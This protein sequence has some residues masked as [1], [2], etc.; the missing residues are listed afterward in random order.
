MDRADHREPNMGVQTFDG[1]KLT[2][3]E[4]NTGKNYLYADKMYRLYLLSEQFLL[5]AESTALAGREMTMASLH[6]QLDRLLELN[7]YPV[8]EG[9]KDYLFDHGDHISPRRSALFMARSALRDI[10]DG[11]RPC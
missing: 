10:R 5:F 11:V 1:K 4:S 3:K 9:W 7:D 6:K 8:F 2:L